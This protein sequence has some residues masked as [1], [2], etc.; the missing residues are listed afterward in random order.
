MR[1]IENPKSTSPTVEG[2]RGGGQD[3]GGAEEERAGPHQVR[4]G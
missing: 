4:D 1:H 2:V 3:G